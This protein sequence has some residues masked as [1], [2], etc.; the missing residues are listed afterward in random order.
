MGENV[1][2]AAEGTS[3]ITDLDDNRI[4]QEYKRDIFI[5]LMQFHSL[6]VSPSHSLTVSLSLTLPL[7]H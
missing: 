7:H 2:G 4:P 3:E 1:N 5:S 6:T